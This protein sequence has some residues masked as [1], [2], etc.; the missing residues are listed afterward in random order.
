MSGGHIDELM[1]I[2]ALSQADGGNSPFS[3]HEDLYATIDAIKHGDAPWKCFKTSYAGEIGRNA[4]SWQ[5]AEYEVWYRDPETVAANL[6][7]N[8]D[9]NGQ[10]DYAPYIELDKNEKRRWSDFMSGNFAWRHSVC[11]SNIIF[12]QSTHLLSF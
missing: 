8:P 2:W 7:D 9:L 3:S 4:P 6:L 11:Y 10:F 1:D 12:Y 5:L